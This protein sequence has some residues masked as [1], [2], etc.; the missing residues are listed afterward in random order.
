MENNFRNYFVVVAVQRS[1]IIFILNNQ[2][3]DKVYGYLRTYQHLKV[4]NTDELNTP[5]A[6]PLWSC[7]PIC[8]NRVITLGWYFNAAQRNICTLK[9]VTAKP[10]FQHDVSIAIQLV[11]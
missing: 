3:G 6:V 1:K 10:I 8:L 7:D 5:K 4:I 11:N 2:V 9:Q